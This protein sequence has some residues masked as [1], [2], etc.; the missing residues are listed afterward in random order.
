MNQIFD[1]NRTTALLKLNLS[2]NKKAI[3][4]A[5]AGFFGFVFITSFFVANNAPSLLNKMHL[6][7][8]FILIYGGT[9][10]IAGRSFWH[11]NSTEKSI[12]HLSLPA[13]TF[14]KYFIPWLLSGI[15]WIFAAIGSYMLYSMIINGLWSGVMGFSYE[16]FNPF[17]IHMGPQSLNEAYMPYFLVHSIFFLGAAAFQKHAIPKTLLAGFI[18]NSLFTFINLLFVMFLFGGFGDFNLTMNSP[19][20][21]EPDFNYFFTD[22]LPRF[23]KTAFVYVIPVIFYVAAFFKIKEREV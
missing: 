9:A 5:V 8:Y 17:N 12:A 10:L 1:I 2:L 3:L 13:S 16:A 4:L 11:L 21:W 15:V 6:I 18:I 19:E 20:S 14:E 7:F 22:F 23:I